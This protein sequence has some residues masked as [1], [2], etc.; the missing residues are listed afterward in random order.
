MC[1]LLEEVHE[2]FFEVTADDVQSVIQNLRNE[3]LQLLLPVVS[4]VRLVKHCS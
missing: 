2:S 4:I 3:R 1:L